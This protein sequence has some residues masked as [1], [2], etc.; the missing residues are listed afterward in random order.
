MQLREFG[1]LDEPHI[2]IVDDE[3][4][5]AG[6]LADVLE[7]S[8]KVRIETSPHA[9]L[10]ALEAD[11]SISVILSDQR[12]PGMTGDKLFMHAKEISIATR[13]LITA[14]AD[15]GAVI[16]AVNEGKIFAYVTKPWHNDDI[17]LTV[18]RA[19]DYCELNRRILHSR[20]LL[21]QLMDSSVDA[22]AI[23]DRDHRYIKLNRT[24]AQILGADNLGEVEGH[25]AAEFLTPDRL[26]SRLRDEVELITTGMPLH[27]RVEQVA[28]FDGQR[29]WY[30]SNLAPIRD[31][32]GDVIGMVGITRDVSESK[33]LDEMKDQFIAT[34]RHELRTPLTAIHAALGLL[35]GGVLAKDG[36]QAARLVEIGHDNCA[37]LLALIGDLLDTVNLEKGEMEFARAPVSIA[38]LIVAAV[39]VHGE[40]ARRKGV[41]LVSEPAPMPLSVDADR[42]RLLQ[43]L[44]KLIVNAIDV[45]PAGCRVTVTACAVGGDKVRLAVLDQGPGVSREAQPRLFKRFSQGD[46]SSTRA[47]G[48]AGLGLYIAKSIID[49]H[50]GTVGYANCVDGGAE[51]FVE[52][53]MCRASTQCNLRPQG[54]S[55]AL[56]RPV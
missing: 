55:D 36:G 51:F 10:A 21:H 53:P 30:S 34:V 49:A 20:A 41:V 19:V 18:R 1:K 48:G 33:R 24:E 6:A 9:A 42:E 35:R 32:Q 29:R 38:E 15:I 40:A 54:R 28:T 22:I 25:T 43:V 7:D 26:Q 52:L 17:M 4:Q 14:Y 56:G 44:A 11:K 37:K 27:D 16:D 47:K 13:V 39:E 23:K 12:M 50:N 46:S 45:T 2:L 5:V 8:F 31:L 3:P